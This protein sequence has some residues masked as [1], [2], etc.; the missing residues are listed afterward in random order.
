MV[1]RVP[2]RRIVMVIRT[3]TTIVTGIIVGITVMVSEN[4]FVRSI[5][6]QAI[7]N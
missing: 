1:V 2:R 5:A 7:A 3:M 6:T 4:A